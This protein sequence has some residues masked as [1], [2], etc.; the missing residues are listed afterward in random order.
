MKYQASNETCLC[1]PDCEGCPGE[2]RKHVSAP[3]HSDRND[4]AMYV[5]FY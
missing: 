3:G 4:G 1:L 2:G 5:V